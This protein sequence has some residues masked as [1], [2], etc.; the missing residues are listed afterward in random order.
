MRPSG[1][2]MLWVPPASITSASPRRITSAASPI[3]WALAAH[4]VWHVAF[5]P[6]RR[7]RPPGAR[8]ASRAP[9]RPRAS[10]GATRSPRL[11]NR[12]VST[13]PSRLERWTRSTN[14]P[15]SCCPSPEPR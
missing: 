9:A 3:A 7:R 14:R 2:I 1:W 6:W 5:G 13:R 12:A 4:A 11:V 15:K 10:G 8:P